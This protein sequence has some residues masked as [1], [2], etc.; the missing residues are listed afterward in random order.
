MNQVSNK[1]AERSR[2]REPREER[3]PG[4]MAGVPLELG[5]LFAQL[6]TDDGEGAGAGMSLSGKKALTGVAMIDALTEQLA[7]RVQAGSQWP[8]QAVL[9][10]PRLGRINATVRREQGSWA[11]DLDAEQ[12]VTAGWL[13]SVRQTCEGRLAQALGAPVSLHLP[14]AGYA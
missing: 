8:L 4:V 7:P 11:I 13:S 12:E 2:Q 6:F 5:R 10:L 1:P 3:E 14:N 9:Y